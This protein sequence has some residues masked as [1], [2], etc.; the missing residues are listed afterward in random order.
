MEDRRL[1][2]ENVK[3]VICCPGGLEVKGKRFKGDLGLTVRWREEMLRLG[4]RGFI[5]YRDGLARGFVE[6][7]SAETAPFPI[8]APGAAV[9]M[10]YHWISADESDEEEH[11]AQER[12]LIELVREEA[13]GEFTGLA[14]LGWDHP[15]HFP[16]A[17]LEEL[18]FRQVER[19]DYIALM[20]LP[21]QKGPQPRMVPARFEPQDLSSQG[22]LAIESAWSSR[23]PYSIHHAARL[24]EAIAAIPE[25]DRGL[26]RHFPHLIDTREE[27]LRWS[28]SPWDWDWLFLNGEE[29]AIHE[30]KG[31]ELQELLMEKIAKL[32]R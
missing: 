6:Y 2:V 29:I 18:G 21:F 25:Q 13:K 9:L 22:L 28:R 17:M 4:M 5:S 10:C 7:M 27:A 12:R 32:K 23:C 16:I 11:L 15:T 31:E 26:I 3:E 20:W 1:T 30:L 24:K 19:T 8:E 14:T